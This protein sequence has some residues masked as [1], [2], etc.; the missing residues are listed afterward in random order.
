M[1]RLSEQSIRF[2]HLADLH[3]GM[4]NYGRMTP[5]G[6]HSR[7]LDFSRTLE[8]VID[9]ALEIDIDAVLFAGDA[10][11]TNQP[12]QT[13]QRE[14]ARHIE[15][16]ASEN[17]PVVMLMGNHDLPPGKGHASS[18]EIFNTLRVPGVRVVDRPDFFTLQ[19]K[20]G[21]LQI[22]A[23]PFP[24]KRNLYALP[25]VDLRQMDENRVRSL[26]EEQLSA[27]ISEQVGQRNPEL[28][29]V[30]LAHLSVTEASLSGTERTMI[31]AEEPKL[32]PGTLTR[33]GIDYAALGHIHRFQDLNREGHPPVVYPGTIERI[34]FGE[35]K[36]PKGFVIAEVEPGRSQ[37]QF[38]PLSTRKFVTIEMDLTKEE[39]PTEALR[40]RV[41]SE[42]IEGA[43]VRIQ[44]IA[45]EEQKQTLDLKAI[46]DI[47]RSADHRAGLSL[48][49]PQLEE[50][51]RRTDLSETSTIEES[52]SA[53]FEQKQLDEEKRIKLMDLARQLEHRLEEKGR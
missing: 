24:S 42:Q 34:D 51:S 21:P 43:V 25:E 4:E 47:L 9:Q 38:Y 50:V 30:V 3:F 8:R 33:E 5:D 17:L 11:K 26:I 52:L 19:T 45:T 7:L 49:P 20:K 32:L 27:Y 14:L 1:Q 39:E 12:T 13:Q 41:E 2:L 37:F 35:A 44:C 31:L 36:D 23:V 6:M 15:R 53:W 28:P 48:R 18:I 29:L 22:V 46:D 10:Y 16:L 40:N